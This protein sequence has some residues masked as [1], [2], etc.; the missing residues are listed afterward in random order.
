M[1]RFFNENICC[2]S[3]LERYQ[4]DGPIKGSQGMFLWKIR[5]IIHK[6]SLLPLL[7]WSTVEAQADMSL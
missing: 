7:I 2:G 6:L 4:T 1:I 5:N 3:S